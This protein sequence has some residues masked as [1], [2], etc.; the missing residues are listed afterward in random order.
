MSCA[1]P[2]ENPEV[3]GPAGG[4]DKTGFGAEAEGGKWDRGGL[5]KA[6]AVGGEAGG[7][8]EVTSGGT[9]GTGADGRKGKGAAGC[10]G[11]RGGWGAGY[12]CGGKVCTEG[13]LGE[14]KVLAAAKGAGA[15]DSAAAEA[16]PPEFGGGVPGGVVSIP[17]SSIIFQFQYNCRLEIV[18]AWQ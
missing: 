11:G 18:S 3:G 4:A 7:G 2:T 12:A 13:P 10:T 8:R 9:E 16:R 17:L 14:G 5:L 6:A 15:E 1:E